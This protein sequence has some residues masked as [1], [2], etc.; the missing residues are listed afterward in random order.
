MRVFATFASAVLLSTMFSKANG[1]VSPAIGSRIGFARTADSC[2]GGCP[3]PP[4]S[5]DVGYFKERYPKIFDA[6]QRGDKLLFLLDQDGT[7][8]DFT[9]GTFVKEMKLVE[10]MIP[11]VRA[12]LD[13]GWRYAPVSARDLKSLKAAYKEFPDLPMAGNNGYYIELAPDRLISFKSSAPNFDE[14]ERW[15]KEFIAERDEDI[16]Y[17]VIG[18]FMEIGVGKSSKYRKDAE[19]LA[20]TLIQ[21]IQDASE[22]TKMWVRYSPDCVSIEPLIAPDKSLPFQI[23]WETMKDEG[24]THVIAAG[25]GGNDIPALKAAKEKGAEGS[26]LWVH[27][28]GPTDPENPCPDYA[29]YAFNDVADFIE[30]LQRLVK[31]AEAL[32]NR[33][34]P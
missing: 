12:F 10:E 24:G 31:V 5:S 21:V 3:L 26:A 6:L 2:E 13:F 23:F 27:A 22:G 19:T 8:T 30:F 4:S 15:V 17:H 25:N 20:I 9:L 33:K 1:F 7:V 14:A 11:L 28:N 29:D 32:G 18:A 16:K 34:K